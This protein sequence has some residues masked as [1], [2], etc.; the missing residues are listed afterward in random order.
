MI[1]P[2]RIANMLALELRQ[3]S[4]ARFAGNCLVAVRAD[5][6]EGSVFVPA[7]RESPVTLAAAHCG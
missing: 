3:V 7:M 6:V 1:S 4:F 5:R 2:M